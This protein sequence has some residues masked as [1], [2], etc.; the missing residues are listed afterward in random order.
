MSITS[1]RE[2]I[3]KKLDEQFNSLIQP[4]T[5]AQAATKRQISEVKSQLRSLTFSPEATIDAE[6][7]KVSEPIICSRGVYLVKVTDRT[8]FDESTFAVQKFTIRENLLR[9][10]K[11]RLYTQWIAKVKE[12]ADITDDRYK[13]W[14]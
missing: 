13:F 1:T 7:N 11:S 2:T 4:A 6:I 9:Q 8:P 12:E 3:C 14:R 10:K 5:S